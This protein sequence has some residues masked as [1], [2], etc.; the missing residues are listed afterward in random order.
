MPLILSR[1]F[2][3]PAVTIAQS[4]GRKSNMAALA[5]LQKQGNWEVGGAEMEGGAPTAGKWGIVSIRFSR[6]IFWGVDKEQWLQ[7][8][9]ASGGQI[10]GFIRGKKN[11]NKNCVSLL[12][13]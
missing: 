11:F 2:S 4:T 10:K 9:E 8:M 3:T 6:Q 13:D 7:K 1:L 5:L 12:L